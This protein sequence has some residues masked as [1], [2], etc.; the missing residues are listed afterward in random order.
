M[1]YFE[2]SNRYIMMNGTRKIFCMSN[3]CIIFSFFVTCYIVLVYKNQQNTINDDTVSFISGMVAWIPMITGVIVSIIYLF[4]MFSE[5]GKK[6]RSKIYLSLLFQF[7]NVILVM[8]PLDITQKINNR[9]SITILLIMF[10]VSFFLHNLI[11]RELIKEN[12]SIKEEFMIMDKVSEEFRKTDL[13]KW[14]NY[15]NKVSWMFVVPFI[16]QPSPLIFSSMTIVIAILLIYILFQYIRCYKED[17]VAADICRINFTIVFLNIVLFI[18]GGILFYYFFGGNIIS[19]I[20]LY[21]SLFSKLMADNKYCLFI[22][23]KL[24]NN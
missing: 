10:I 22:R 23:G 14:S 11:G 15:F 21:F 8:L 12:Y 3:N 18:F 24:N 4:I 6:L 20:I 7:V 17:T 19:F 5:T 2:T 13:Y 16:I 9:I 1:F